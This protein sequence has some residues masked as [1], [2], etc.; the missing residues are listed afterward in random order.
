MLQFAVIVVFA[1]AGN[2]AELVKGFGIDQSLDTF[3]DGKP[4]LVV[5]TLD[6]VSAAHLPRERFAPREI[7]E[8]PASSS[9]VP[10][11]LMIFLWASPRPAWCRSDC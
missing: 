5:L 4:A 2:G 1:D 3:A 7:V 9:F 6:L 8:P 10:S 11:V